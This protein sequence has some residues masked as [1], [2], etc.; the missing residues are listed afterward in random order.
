ME[1]GE[2]VAQDLCGRKTRV[3]QL[4]KYFISKGIT[5]VMGRLR[6]KLRVN[7]YISL[8]GLRVLQ[9]RVINTFLRVKPVIYPVPKTSKNTKTKFL[10]VSD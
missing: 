8:W 1:R 2:R 5:K 9:L 7:P 10:R 6:V 3:L 4:K